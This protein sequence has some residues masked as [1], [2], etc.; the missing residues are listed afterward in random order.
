MS[1]LSGGQGNWNAPVWF[2]TRPNASALGP[3]DPL[4]SF[5]GAEAGSIKIIEATFRYEHGILEQFQVLQIRLPI[6]YEPEPIEAEVQPGV[7]SLKIF[8]ERTASWLDVDPETNHRRLV[9]AIPDQRR[10]GSPDILVHLDTTVAFH[11]NLAFN[12]TRPI[13]PGRQT[14]WHILVA[15][16]RSLFLDQYQLESVK[17][18]SNIRVKVFGRPDLEAPAYSSAA[19]PNMGQITIPPTASQSQLAFSIPLHQRYQRPSD[20]QRYFEVGLPTILAFQEMPGD[21]AAEQHT[22]QRDRLLYHRLI[23]EE[24]LT[25]AMTSRKYPSS[26]YMPISLY[27]TKERGGSE[28][29]I[30][31]VDLWA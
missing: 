12:I 13:E 18:P 17:F 14:S 11:P 4:L 21:E 31:H 25:I 7:S 23:D 9:L 3:V 16:D 6:N 1:L 8:D 5:P 15:L 20:T 19:L 30:F 26:S 22:G 10:T 27:F 2:E 29:V 24:H 28:T